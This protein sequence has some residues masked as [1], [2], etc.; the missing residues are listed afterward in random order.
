MHI[1]QQVFRSSA[2]YQTWHLISNCFYE[3]VEQIT[4]DARYTLIHPICNHTLTRTNRCL[5]DKYKEIILKS[6]CRYWFNLF[7]KVLLQ[8]TCKQNPLQEKSCDLLCSFL[9]ICFYEF[10][11]RNDIQARMT[12]YYR[13]L[14]LITRE[15]PSVSLKTISRPQQNRTDQEGRRRLW[16]ND[17]SNCYGSIV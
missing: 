10:N 8:N 4:S 16:K 15:K 12:C 7:I 9:R 14:V 17:I 13:L 6:C 5:L 1:F 11:F 3:D 2:L